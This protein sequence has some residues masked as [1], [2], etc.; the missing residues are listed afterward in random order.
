[1][2]GDV[3]YPNDTDCT[4]RFDGEGLYWWFQKYAPGNKV[5]EKLGTPAEGGEAGCGE[6]RIRFHREFIESSSLR[7]CS[8]RKTGRP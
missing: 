8:P 5:L 1:M 3:I 6:T 7:R 2:I 4:R